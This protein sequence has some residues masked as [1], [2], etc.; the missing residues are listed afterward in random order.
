VSTPQD[1]LP[2]ALAY[3]DRARRC[4]DIIR[5]HIVNQH[6]G[7]WAAIRLSDG[8]S[9]GIP[10]ELREHAIQYQLHEQQCAY[11]KIPLDDMSPAHAE[12]YLRAVTQL[13]DAGMRLIDP[14]DPRQLFVSNRMEH[15]Q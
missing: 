3:S 14:D 10:Y 5:Q 12:R 2:Q 13:Y 1:A 8:G 15:H 7:F 4:S 9:D 11:I 6:G